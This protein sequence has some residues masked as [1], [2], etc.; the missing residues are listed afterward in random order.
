MASLH[1]AGYCLVVTDDDGEDF[2]YDDVIDYGPMWSGDDPSVM[3]GLHVK[4]E[5]HPRLIF[6]PKPE[7]V[8][9]VRRDT[10]EDSA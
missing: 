7:T 6:E 10:V 8:A 9:L 1:E 5:S 2:V 3:T 4:T